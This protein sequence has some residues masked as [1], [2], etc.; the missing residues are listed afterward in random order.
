MNEEDNKMS[1]YI[2]ND[3]QKMLV[4]IIKSMPCVSKLYI[5]YNDDDDLTM[6]VDFIDGEKDCRDIIL[7]KNHLH[8]IHHQAHFESLI[9]DALA[10][11]LSRITECLVVKYDGS[12]F[13]SLERE[14]L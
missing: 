4:D 7:H 3:T 14:E 9:T 2:K 1:K 5:D 11:I 10:N 13:K 12:G 6:Y 8:K